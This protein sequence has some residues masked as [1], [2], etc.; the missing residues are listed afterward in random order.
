[1]E[2]DKNI[3]SSAL[4]K[5]KSQLQYASEKQEKSWK[6]AIAELKGDEIA[7]DVV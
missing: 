6:T 3:S 1:M 2:S 4:Q 7:A 5:E